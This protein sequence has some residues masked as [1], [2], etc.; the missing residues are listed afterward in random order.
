MGA[1]NAGWR[2]KCGLRCG[3]C[4][5]WPFGCDTGQLFLDRPFSVEAAVLFIPTPRIWEHVDPWT[6]TV[7]WSRTD[8]LIG[9]A[10]VIWLIGRVVRHR[11]GGRSH[12]GQDA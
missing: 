4:N 3:N 9:I 1:N 10:T 11:R 5:G 12:Q 8:S 6:S 2:K 7:M